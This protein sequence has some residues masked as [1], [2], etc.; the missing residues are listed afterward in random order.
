M[1]TD[2]PR[3]WSAGRFQLDL[4]RV[5]VMGIVNVTPDSFSDGGNHADTASALRHARRL[6][7]EGA[8]VLDVGGES[9]RPGAQPVDADEEWR[10]V[11]P[12]LREL[13]AWRVP[14]SI[15]TYQVPTMARALELGVDIVNDIG[16]LRAPGAEAL[17]AASS[18]GVCLMHM[19][20]QP[21]DMQRAPHYG[22]VVAEVAAFL[23]ARVDALRA[24][25]VD[26]ARLCVDP[27]F[28]FG[29]TLEHNVALARGLRTIAA[30]GQPLLV[31]VSRKSMIGGMAGRAAGERLPGSLAAALA[32]VAAGARI[33]RVHDVAA[34]VDALAVWS[35]LREDNKDER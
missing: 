25:G 8:D 19:Q 27:G 20:G 30:L 22:D 7:D 21:R 32:C 1:S 4:E 6:L 11:G 16:A 34:T 12:L 2:L 33:V 15:D 14:L 29:K 3:R 13:V 10:R 18:A 35:A 23:R 26:A 28:G 24:R 9:T 5:R 31:G 17:V